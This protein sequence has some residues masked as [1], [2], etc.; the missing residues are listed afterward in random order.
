MLSSDPKL[1]LAAIV[2]VVLPLL[3]VVTAF[4]FM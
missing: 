1:L 2:G 4:I 3:L